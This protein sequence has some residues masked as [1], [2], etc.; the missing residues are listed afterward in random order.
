VRSECAR[1]ETRWS[2]P[3][4]RTL[5]RHG[6]SAPFS[7]PCQSNRPPVQSVK[8]SSRE[9]DNTRQ[10]ICRLPSCVIGPSEIAI[11][12]FARENKRAGFTRHRAD[13]IASI[14]HL[15]R[16][17]LLDTTGF[18]RD[19]AWLLYLVMEWLGSLA[20]SSRRRWEAT[21]DCRFTSSQAR[22][23]LSHPV[24]AYVMPGGLAIHT[25]SS[26]KMRKSPG[27]AFTRRRPSGRHQPRRGL[28]GA[29]GRPAPARAAR[30]R[31]RFES[32]LRHWPGVRCARHPGSESARHPVRL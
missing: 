4:C 21:V 19:L 16:N 2:H 12:L 17:A 8:S 22:W 3:T 28:R 7:L 20:L 31:D 6:R 23:R 15:L 18:A 24:R 14:G 10:E 1:S 25:L 30:L 29:S 32:S 13:I 26:K 9:T 5:S 27:V 11:S